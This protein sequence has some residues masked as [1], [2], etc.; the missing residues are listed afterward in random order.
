METELVALGL[1]PQD[2]G[3]T[4]SLTPGER[5]TLQFQSPGGTLHVAEKVVR[6]SVTSPAVLATSLLEKMTVEIPTDT[7]K[8]W[9]W[10]TGLTTG[11]LVVT[12]G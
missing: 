9:V 6:P 8:I 3:V 12:S 11:S 1:T 4:L 2:L 7:K 5:Y 10:I